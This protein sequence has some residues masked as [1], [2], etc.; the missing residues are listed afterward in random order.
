MAQ[1]SEDGTN[2]EAI[3]EEMWATENVR[4]TLREEGQ[5]E[6][7]YFDPSYDYMET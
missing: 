1:N 7:C 5:E 4:S 2:K 3:S 6:T